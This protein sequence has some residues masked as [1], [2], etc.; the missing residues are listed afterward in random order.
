MKGLGHSGSGAMFADT[1]NGIFTSSGVWFHVTEAALESYAAP[2]LAHEPLPVLLARA[3]RWLRSAQTLTVWLLPVLLLVVPPLS[4]VLAAL[5]F[6]VGWRALSPAFTSRAV[7]TVLRGLDLVLVQGLYYVMMLSFFAAREQFVLVGL[8]LAGFVL[9]RWGLVDR[10]VQPL[11]R[12]LWASLFPLPAADQVL[13]GFIIRAA[14]AY[15]VALP[16]LDRMEET[17][18]RHLGRSS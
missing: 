13:R 18:R 3:E 1:P 15:G 9:L 16:Q 6:F 2:V 8:G 12:R 14:L 4:A 7:D 17:I 5:T 10:L 11:V